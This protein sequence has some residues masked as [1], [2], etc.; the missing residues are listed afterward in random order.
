M[1]CIGFVAGTHGLKGEIKIISDFEYK[2]MVFQK[3]NHLYILDDNLVINSYRK[4]KNY[5]MVTLL[6]HDKIEDVLK[7]KGE[8]VYINR[9]DYI[10]PSILLDDL[11]GLDVYGNGKLIGR[12][13]SI[14][15]NKSQKLMLI[16]KNGKN[17]YIP[18]VS[19]FIKNISK[20]KIEVNVIEGLIDEN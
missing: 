1:F 15:D 3:G 12:L 2:E 9:S 17:I 11:I 20:D 8:K 19:Q 7:Y 18:Y 4:H 10:F 6:D 16:K 5:D 14:I 13:A